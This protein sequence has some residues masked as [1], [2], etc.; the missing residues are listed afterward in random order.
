MWLVLQKFNIKTR[1]TLH[2]VQEENEN[3]VENNTKILLHYSYLLQYM[4]NM[5]IVLEAV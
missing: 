1:L 3:G 5:R 4:K 2:G